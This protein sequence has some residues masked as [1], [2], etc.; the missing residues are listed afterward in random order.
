MLPL[1]FYSASYSLLFLLLLLL[2]PYLC[3]WAPLT[4][5]AVPGEE[6][7]I[8]LFLTSFWKGLFFPPLFFAL[9]PVTPFETVTVIKGYT[10]LTRMR[11]QSHTLSL[12]AGL[13]QNPTRFDVVFALFR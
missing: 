9:W 4:L 7:F 13:I 12:P 6:H 3:P 1:N 10:K 8:I 2:L 5:L 11:A